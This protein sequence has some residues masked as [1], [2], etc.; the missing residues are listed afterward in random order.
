MKSM[1]T[2]QPGYTPGYRQP[3]YWHPFRLLAVVA[4]IATLVCGI[5]IVFSTNLSATSFR[6]WVGAGIISAGVALGCLI[7][8]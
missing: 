3:G 2:P 1:T 5:F 7:I 6:D 4:T 8:L